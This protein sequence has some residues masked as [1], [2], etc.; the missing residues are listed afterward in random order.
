MFLIFSST[1]LIQSYHFLFGFCELKGNVPY[2]G[3]IN[4]GPWAICSPVILFVC[5]DHKIRID[6]Y[7]F[8]WLTKQTKTKIKGRIIFIGM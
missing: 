6:L 5:L 1:F 8:K 4:C 7:S 2:Q 3:S